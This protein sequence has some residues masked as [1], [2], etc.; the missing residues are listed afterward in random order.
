M[1]INQDFLSQIKPD[2]SGVLWLTNT[3]LR[4]KSDLHETLDYLVDGRLYQFLNK[5]TLDN[6]EYDSDL[7]NY[8]VSQSFGSPFFLIHKKGDLNAK[9]DLK[10]IK[11]LLQS[12]TELES[13]KLMIVS[14][15]Q[16]NFRKELKKLEIDSII[17]S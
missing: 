16:V 9:N 2:I 1:S 6:P 17:Y 10:Q 7:F 12:N 8:F 14:E 13:I 5:V 15:H 4:E 3:P 11:N